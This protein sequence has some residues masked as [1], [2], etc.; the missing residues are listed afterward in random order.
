M[1]PC[2]PIMLTVIVLAGVVSGAACGPRPAEGLGQPA[3]GT[4]GFDARANRFTSIA[5]LDRYVAVAWIATEATLG[6]DVY[7]AMSVDTGR[8]FA[9]PIRINWRPGSARAGGEQPPRVALVPRSAG[10]PDV[11]AFWLGRRTT[12]R[13]LLTT[14]SED[15]GRTYAEP[16]LVAGTDTT[17]ERGWQTLSV[18]PEREIALAWVDHRR[19]ASDLYIA[20]GV[21][22]PDPRVIA[23]DVCAGSRTALAHGRN[24][25]MYAV[26]RHI[27]AADERDIAIASSRDGGR[28]WTPPARISDDHWSSAGCPDEGPTM[29]VDS[30]GRLHLVWPTVVTT[31]DGVERTQLFYASSDNG[32]DFTTRL[33][34]P[35]PHH[36]R[37]PRVATLADDTVA[38][39]WDSPRGGRS[40]V[41]RTIGRAAA[42]GTWTF[43]API[44]VGEGIYPAVAGTVEG[45][46]LSWMTGEEPDAKIQTRAEFLW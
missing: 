27:F 22:D 26:W 4:L 18:G 28:T 5:A 6:T 9:D 45:L 14:R 8:T 7:V 44:D 12:G 43:D 41:W 34:I 2:L 29:T 16:T 32:T 40:H 15:G 11:V 36:A 1:R 17:G 31:A 3:R 20:T 35:F 39:T 38:V 46:V 19:G 25:V 13:V 10:P 23:R 33:P 21:N 24:G 37:H 42:D 30:R